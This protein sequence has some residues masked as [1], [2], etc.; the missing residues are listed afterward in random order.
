MVLMI[1]S[2]VITRKKKQQKTK[3]KKN[4]HN[5]EKKKNDIS[6]FVCHVAHVLFFSNVQ[7]MAVFLLSYTLT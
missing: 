2:A 7:V 4:K 3:K 1:L 5:P 6:E